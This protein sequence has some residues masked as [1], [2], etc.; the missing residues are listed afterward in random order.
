M[1]ATGLPAKQQRLA[2]IGIT[3]AAATL[4]VAIVGVGPLLDPIRDDLG[5]RGRSPGC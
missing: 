1:A 2:L 3:A 4:R 5:S